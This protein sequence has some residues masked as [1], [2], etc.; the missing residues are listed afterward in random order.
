M[1]FKNINLL[2]QMHAGGVITLTSSFFI[3][4]TYIIAT[5]VWNKRERDVLLAVSALLCLAR[6]F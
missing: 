4:A 2:K 3:V 6:E 5:L 1:D